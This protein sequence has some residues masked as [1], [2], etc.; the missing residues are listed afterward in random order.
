MN[1]RPADSLLSSVNAPSNAGAPRVVSFSYANR[2][3]SLV[4]DANGRAVNFSYSGQ[5]MVLRFDRRN[6]IATFSFDS[7]RQFDRA[8]ASGRVTTI[9]APFTRGGWCGNRMTSPGKVELTIDGSRTDVAD[10]TRLSLDRFGAP[11]RVVAADSSVTL[12][13]RT[14]APFPAFVTSLT[15]ADGTV[16]AAIPDARGNV[17]SL[18]VANPGMGYTAR[19]TTMQYDQRWD[20]LTRVV[21]PEGDSLTFGY[22]AVTSQRL[23][24][25]IG[26][27]TTTYAYG[28]FGNSSGLLTSVFHPGARGGASDRDALE[29]DALG[30]VS[31]AQELTDSSGVIG[32]V[33]ART[34]LLHDAIGQR[35]LSCQLIQSSGEEHCLRSGY[36]LVGRDTLAVDSAS[37]LSGTSAQWVT[38]RTIRDEEGNPTLVERTPSSGPV[39]PMTTGWEYNAYGEPTR[40]WDAVY[41]T[42]LQMSYDGGGN[43]TTLTTPRGTQSSLYD[44]RNRRIAVTI[45]GRSFNASAP[46]GSIGQSN[47]IPY[48]D[49][50]RLGGGS[51]YTI[52]EETHTFQYD[53][54]SQLTVATT[55]DTRIL[56][57]YSGGGEL[58]RDSMEM[59][60]SGAGV[61]LGYGIVHG[62][63]RN[64]RR[65][66]TSV[67]SPFATGVPFASIA[68]S[69]DSG[70]GELHAVR[71]VMGL[72]YVYAYTPRGEVAQLDYASGRYRQRLLYDARG[73]VL[74]DS[75]T[76]G[77]SVLRATRFS[78]DLRGKQLTADDNVGREDEFRYTYS[79]LGHLRT[80]RML[81]R[82]APVNDTT[83]TRVVTV[84]DQQSDPFGNRVTVLSADTVSF[85]PSAP[86][87]ALSTL[88]YE[89]GSGRLRGRNAAIT[90]QYLYDGAGDEVFAKEVSGGRERDRVS[91]Y[92]ATG[93]LRAVDARE[94]L[95][96]FGELLATF[97]EYR[98]DALGR[99][100]R[101]RTDRRC[102]SGPGGSLAPA[103]NQGMLR[104]LVWDGDQLLGEIQVPLKFVTAT[105]ATPDSVQDNDLYQ[106]QLV[107]QDSDTPALAK[108]PNPFFGR[109]LYTHGLA[110]DQPV[111][112]TRFAYVDRLRNTPSAVEFPP[113]PLALFWTSTGALGLAGCG[114]GTAGLQCRA[115][116]ASGRQATMAVVLPT[117]IFAYQR[118]RTDFDFFQGSLLRDQQETTGLL[119][120]RARS[121]DPATGRFTQ[122]DPIGLAGGLNLYGFANGDPVNFS[123]PFGLCVPFPACALA[124]GRAGAGVGTLVGAG[125]G[126]LAAGAGAIPGAVIGNRVG[127]VVG[128]SAA[129]VGAIYLAGQHRLGADRVGTEISIAGEH[130]DR[131]AG[132]PPDD[133]DP[134]FVR[135]MVNHAQRHLNNA[136]KY[137]EKVSGKTRRELDRQ[138]G[139]MQRRVDE[140]RQSVPPR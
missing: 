98:Y 73:F 23:F 37:A 43:L 14:S 18:T 105:V 85:P 56:R 33:N 8:N 89:A 101:V 65:I 13:E 131:V 25:R 124:A 136:K 135:D 66:F 70:T 53:R 106:P 97:E 45:G 52:P 38:V 57:T 24:S 32:R 3:L 116:N 138:I 108:D 127:W 19:T 17:A 119:Y 88:D 78:Y 128:A 79:G 15:T 126:A 113:Q 96:S 82:Q 34:R 139:D 28:T 118:P 74:R 114:S 120:R 60:G 54:M 95:G 36:D 1:Y 102:C 2:A 125:V 11:T 77:G 100:V 44:S 6:H 29:Y 132:M 103:L 35:T 92:D 90:P 81:Q 87:T 75:I 133:D 50:N 71:D 112:S 58:V 7:L 26:L 47:A 110:L 104:R 42:R 99:R 134:R 48:P 10:I 61:W 40:E 20:A 68:R 27:H 84:E 121:Y 62:Y 129:T 9:C 55:P 83:K 69:Y 31:L 67:P 51:S 93:R 41:G 137:V 72:S 117:T 91:F 86:P 130:M 21:K 16:S 4:V 107:P 94:R 49:P 140:A 59:R 5:Q 109:V 22:D 111:A 39:G 76:F 30:N 64:G 115:T 46:A 80:S 122:E 12:L 123:D 63:D